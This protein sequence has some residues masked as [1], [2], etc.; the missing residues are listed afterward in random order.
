MGKF[1]RSLL[2][3]LIL[4]LMLRIIVMLW[5]F[6]F[7]E[8]T[9]I[10]R[11]R[12]WGR[13]SYLYSLSDTYKTDYL[14]FGTIPNN[15]P[16]GSLYSINLMYNLNMQV[17]KVLLKITHS[18]EGSLAWMNGPLLN[19][20]LRFPAIIAD[21]L[22]G[23]L[24]YKVV[25]SQ[26]SKRIGLFTTS[27]FLFNPV[28]LYN[29]AFWGQ[30][31][32]INNFFFY[33]SLFLL[34]KKKYFLSILFCSLSLY[35]KLSFLPLLPIFFLILYLLKKN[36][37]QLFISIISSV[38]LIV[39]L[40]FPISPSPH[41]WLIQFFT[42]NLLPE[43]KNITSFSFN[44]WWL[45]FKPWISIGQP[46]D[47]FNFS[48]IRL[49]DSPLDSNNFLNISLGSW[50][51]ILFFTFLTPLFYKIISI[52]SR[53]ASKSNLFLIFSIIAI[54]F[55]LFL[56]DMHERYF[57]PFFPLFATYVGLSQKNLSIFIFLS[58]LN[59]IN[60]YLVWH[61][62]MLPLISYEFMNN[63][64]FQWLISLLTIIIASILYIKSIKVI[65]ETK[66]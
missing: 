61:P 3:L 48:E 34:V 62:M 24:I 66:K 36:K 53:I 27:L 11:Y 28:I 9:D 8:N 15:M 47:L 21:L 4:G 60:L 56:P 54:L 33:F 65:Y 12:D 20:F 44:F 57:Y 25:T 41:T 23:F 52:K 42:Q 17:S 31:D 50:G 13:I 5:S 14:N 35:V 40:T 63:R 29:S 55:Y 2:L 7:R 26:R 39:I 46:T 19:F 49:I 37:L 10:L 6:N 1:S 16:P 58:L 59:F 51:Y 30:M 18:K 32:A 22:M 64:S 38:F 45:I 43:M